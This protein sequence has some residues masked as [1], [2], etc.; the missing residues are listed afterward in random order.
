MQKYK[1][2]QSLDKQRQLQSKIRRLEKEKENIRER[3]LKAEKIISDYETYKWRNDGVDVD[4]AAMAK[5][6]KEKFR[7]SKRRQ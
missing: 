5:A 7:E 2:V 1:A 4:L 3:A 6:E